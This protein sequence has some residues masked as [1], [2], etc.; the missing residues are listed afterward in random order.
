MTTDEILADLIRA[1]FTGEKRDDLL[2]EL[3]GKHKKKDDEEKEAEKSEQ[4]KE[5]QSTTSTT[6]TV[7]KA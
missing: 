2:A 3:E 7:R 5:Q 6:T 1:V 4:K